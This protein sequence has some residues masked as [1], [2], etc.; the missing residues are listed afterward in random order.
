MSDSTID[1]A[2]KL[3]EI[4]KGNPDR[5]KKIIKSFQK[6]SLISLEDRK[7]IDALVSQYLTPRQRVSIKKIDETKEKITNFPRIRKQVNEEFKP[8]K[9]S[10]LPE[11][12][13]NI[14]ESN[15]KKTHHQFCIK[16]GG[17]NP[18]ENNFCNNCGDRLQ[19]SEVTSDSVKIEKEE[20]DFE[21]FERE[22]V[23]RQTGI[24]TD[25]DSQEPILE[26]K[27]VEHVETK[28]LSPNKKSNKK[29]IGI[30]IGILALLVVAGGVAF[31]VNNIDLSSSSLVEDRISCDD[32]P[33]LV[34]S[35]KI[36]GFPNPEKDLQYYLDRYNN[37]PSYADWF[38][39]NFPGQ[40]IQETLVVSSSESIQS[41]IPGFPNPEKDLQY[42]LDRYNNE[43]SYADWFDRNFPGQ[44]IQEAVC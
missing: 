24:K 17:V 10:R 38:D 3:L 36:P 32:K 1:D 2:L 41:K 18:S 26:E 42:Y 7:Y 22:Y 14:S 12:N 25:S 35:T 28:R 8:R 37:E 34:S 23:E 29:F 15:L 11:S 19:S 4:G 16:C 13:V 31:M 21:K 43:P 20:T 9:Y 30:G 44:T 5:V 6:R 39:R 33:I 27:F 40:T